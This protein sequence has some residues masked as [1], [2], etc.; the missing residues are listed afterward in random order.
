MHDGQHLTKPA[1]CRW[2][3]DGRGPQLRS[4]RELLAHARELCALGREQLWALALDDNGRVRAELRLHGDVSGVR[5]R[6]AELLAP[7]LAAGVRRLL[8]VH[9]HP[10]GDPR[11]SALDVAFTQRVA[12]AARLLGVRLCDHLIVSRGGWQAVP[13]A[14]HQA[15]L[16]AA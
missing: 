6:P 9:N 8:L 4:R 2:W 13:L 11:P 14:T 15:Q 3:C 1:G 7:V 10:S 16:E 5:A 12:A